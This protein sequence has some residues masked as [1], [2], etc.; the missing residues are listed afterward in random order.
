VIHENVLLAVPVEVH[1]PGVFLVIG[2]DDRHVL[3]P[4]GEQIRS[5]RHADNDVQT[6]R[7]VLSN[8]QV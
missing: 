2:Y 1:Q 4:P 8:E 6:V 5:P 7:S 3:W